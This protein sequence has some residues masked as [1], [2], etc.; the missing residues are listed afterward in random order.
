VRYCLKGGGIVR[1]QN[2]VKLKEKDRV[3]LQQLISKGK[4]KARTLNR[5]HILILADRGKSDSEIMEVLGIARN[6]VR[7]VRQRYVKEGI[8]AAIQERRRPGAP[9]KFSGKQLA[10]ITALACSKAP[11]GRN[12]WSLRLLADKVVELKLVDAI[13]YKTIERTLKKTNLS[14]I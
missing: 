6:T 14:L 5:C 12:R 4:I 7:Q 3:K 1:K 13:S 2:L 10:H 9:K 8:E 11:E